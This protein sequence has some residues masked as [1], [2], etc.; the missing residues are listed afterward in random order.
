MGTFEFR[1]LYTREREFSAKVTPLMMYSFDSI[2]SKAD[3]Y[4]MTFAAPYTWKGTWSKRGYKL[5]LDPGYEILLMDA[6]NDGAAENLMNSIILNTNLTLVM[7]GEW[8]ATYKLEARSDDSLSAD[9][10]N[11]ANSDALKYAIKTSQI[12]LLD[13]SK[14]QALIVNGGYVINAAEGKD[15]RYNR[16]ELGMTYSQPF[17][18]WKDAS[19]NSGLSTYLLNYPDATTTRKDTNI[20]LSGGISKPINKKYSWGANATYVSN[21][22]DSSTN[23][24]TKYTLMG[25]LS[26]R[27]SNA[28]ADSSDTADTA[29]SPE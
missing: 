2:F 21:Q 12:F 1:P 6:N 17:K 13:Q 10:L 7:S 14:K 29:T 19:W 26:Y 23:Q 11:D 5:S 4:M 18:A 25:T 28:P 9:S 22:S 27:W 20:T 16:L 15:K 24:Y 8:F 3:P